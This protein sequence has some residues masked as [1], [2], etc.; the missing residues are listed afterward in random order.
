MPA[1]GVAGDGGE[2]GHD[3]ARDVG[4]RAEAAGGFRCAHRGACGA[5]RACTVRDAA[6]G[7][8][9]EGP[10]FELSP[11]LRTFGGAKKTS[12]HRGASPR[13]LRRCGDGAM[14]VG[15][16]QPSS[17]EESTYHGMGQSQRWAW[18]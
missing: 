7:M 1:A 5:D 13:R 6:S 11:R 17:G 14:A 8:G 9:Q 16:M 3:D 2:G 4:C 18:V 12:A 15:H 10:K